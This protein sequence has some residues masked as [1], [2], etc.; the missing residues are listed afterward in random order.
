VEPG[1]NGWL[2][3]AGSAE[4]LANAMHELLTMDPS[5]VARLGAAGRERVARSH[6]VRREAALL[7]ELWQQARR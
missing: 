5:A 3:T 1:T 6:D 7:R 2:V 4:Q